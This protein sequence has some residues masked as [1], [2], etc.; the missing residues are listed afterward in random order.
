MGAEVETGW[1]EEG[2]GLGVGAGWV[3]VGW[4]VGADSRGSLWTMQGGISSRYNTTLYAVV[5]T[6]RQLAIDDDQA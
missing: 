1:G 4:A 5:G 6:S 3:G 2:E